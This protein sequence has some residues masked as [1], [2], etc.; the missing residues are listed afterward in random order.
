MRLLAG[1]LLLSLAW[2]VCAAAQEAR[3]WQICAN[4]SRTYTPQRQTQACTAVLESGQLTREQVAVALYNRGN[5]SLAL[6]NFIP[7]VEDYNQ[8]IEAN[9][10][11]P[12]P[13]KARCWAQSVIGRLD[14]ALHD[15]SAALNLMPNQDDALESRGLVYLRQGEFESARKDFDKALQINAALA[16]SLFGRGIAKIRLGDANGGNADLMA[17]RV[18]R[19]DI[20]TQFARFGLKP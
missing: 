9:P 13:Y 6:G 20:D 19:R 17:A 11:D 15:C 10:T 1:T 12:G 8:S 2:P 18:L 16:G 14:H 4:A 3:E 7:A 5:A